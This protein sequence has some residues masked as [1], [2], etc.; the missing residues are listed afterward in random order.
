MKLI[1]LLTDFGL[2]DSFVGIMKG[3]IY[4]ICPDANIVDLTHD[5]PPQ[6]VMAGALALER[7]VPYFPPGT[8]HVAVVDPGVGTPRSPLAA[9]IGTQYVV[10]PDNG[11]FT[12][13]YKR[14]EKNGEMLEVVQLNQ[15]QYWLAEISKVFHGRDIFA[16]V[17]AHLASGVP[18]SLLGSPL[19]DFKRL[20]FPQARREG[21]TW[22]CQ[23]IAIDHFGTLQLNLS[24]ADLQQAEVKQVCVAGEKINGLCATFGERPAGEL[25]TLPDSSGHLSIAV[26]NGSAAGRLNVTVGEEVQVELKN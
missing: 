11:L 19:T 12:C 18:L 15:P 14:A 10:G 5:I 2:S 26:V 1:T 8:V 17:G 20:N 6:S 25:M 4:G 7:A 23:V 16:P 3:V 22:F 9:R 24:M 21:Y 13:L